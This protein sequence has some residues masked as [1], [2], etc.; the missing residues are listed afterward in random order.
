MLETFLSY[1]SKEKRLSDHTLLAYRK[2][3]EQF[4]EF[5]SKEFEIQDSSEAQHIHLRSWVVSLSE[6]DLSSSSINRKIASLKSFYKYLL[7]RELIE[8]NPAN[9]LRPLKT[10]KDLPSFVKEDE[11]DVLLTQ[12]EFAD[13]FSGIRDRLLLELLYATGI[14]LSELIGTKEADINQFDSSV[15]V[16]GKR[17]KERIIPLGKVQLELISQEQYVQPVFHRA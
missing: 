16:L 3:L 17:N 1:I 6:L 4:H 5:L 15:K 14:R 2:D 13:D 10:S 12:L 9:Q 7:T 11:V 8:Q